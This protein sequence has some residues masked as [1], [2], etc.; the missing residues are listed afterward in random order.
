MK[1]I[2]I[3]SGPCREKQ[4]RPLN[5]SVLGHVWL[6]LVGPTWKQCRNHHLDLEYC[7]CGY[8]NDILSGPKRTPHDQKL[9]SKMGSARLCRNFCAEIPSAHVW[10]RTKKYLYIS[11]RPYLMGFRDHAWVYQGDLTTR[12]KEIPFDGGTCPKLGQNHFCTTIS[13]QL[14][15]PMFGP[16]LK[17]VHMQT[18]GSALWVLKTIHWSVKWSFY[19]SKTWPLV[20]MNWTQT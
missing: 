5:F 7:M 8:N 3:S 20:I 14:Q 9:S 19:F 17:I 18:K 13:T 4:W 10:P 2:Q 6:S 16:L 11:S 15:V 1:K 12:Q